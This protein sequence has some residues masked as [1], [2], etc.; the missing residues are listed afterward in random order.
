METACNSF[1]ASISERLEQNPSTELRTGSAVERLELM[2]RCVNT[3]ANLRVTANLSLAR[4]SW[5]YYPTSLMDIAFMQQLEG[6]R[7]SRQPS[8]RYRE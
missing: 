7:F 4:A 5:L 8:A 6:N 3:P 1:F 2:E